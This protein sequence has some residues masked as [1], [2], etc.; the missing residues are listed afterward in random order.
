[1]MYDAREVADRA[2]S[3]D[4]AP[5]LTVRDAWTRPGHRRDPARRDQPSR[6]F[7]D[8]LDGALVDVGVHR[9]VAYRDVVDAH[10]GGHPYTARRGIDKLKRAGLLEERQAKG[11]QGGTFSVLT[12]TRGGAKLAQKLA[13][14]RGYAA[15]QQA[16]SGLGRAADL[17]HDIAIYRAAADARDRIAERKGVV[18]RIRLDAELRRT[19][20]RRSER[21]RA[22]HGRA[23]ADRERRR[24]ARDLGLPVRDD[25]RVLYPDAQLE[26]STGDGRDPGRV[27]IEIATEHYRDSAVA[28]KAL[29]GFAVYA[30]SSKAAGAVSSGLKKAARALA[31]AAG[32]GGGGGGG[33]DPDPAS[34]EL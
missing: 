24:A 26:Y 7:Q 27:N 22:T 31:R 28:Q 17:P 23:A 33:R 10:F 18:S 4:P 5:R 32:S 15:R 16:W 25:G 21:V 34:V 9:V 20:A 6:P 29:A 2:P 8:R 30:A 3:A 11:P 14:R 12:T 1:M 19:V 13:V